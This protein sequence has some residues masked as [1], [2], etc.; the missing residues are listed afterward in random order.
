MAGARTRLPLSMTTLSTHDTKRSEDARARIS[1]IAELP[2]GVGR[3]AGHAPELAPIPDGPYENLL[4]QAIVGAWPASRERLQG[5][6][7]KAAREAGNST[8]WTDPDEDFE[9]RVKAAVDAAF[10]DARRHHRGGGLRGPDRL[11][12]RVQLPGRQ[13][14][15]ADHARRSGRLPGHR[16]LG[17]V[18]D[19]PGQPPPGGLCAAGKPSWPSIDAGT[20]PAAGTEASKLLVTSRALRLRRDRPELFQGYGPVTATGAAAGHLLGVPPRRG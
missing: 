8:T 3:H 10:D 12:R 18:P 19:R 2:D 1:V 13:A 15:P 6:A 5:Y 11:L 4:W 9:S 17:T 20:L 14:G 16:V 7:E